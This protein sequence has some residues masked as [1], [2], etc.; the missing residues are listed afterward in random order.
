MQRQSLLTADQ[1][2]LPFA[3]A[4]A[5]GAGGAGPSAYTAGCEVK[6][7]DGTVFVRQAVARVAPDPKRPVTVLAWGEGESEQLTEK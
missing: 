3:G 4:G 1:K 2:A 7:P 5:F 6:M